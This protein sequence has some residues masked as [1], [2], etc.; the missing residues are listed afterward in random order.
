MLG[1]RE[2]KRVKE[3]W[4]VSSDVHL[5]HVAI[6]NHQP[7]AAREYCASAKVCSALN[8]ESDPNG[9]NKLSPRESLRLCP[10][11]PNS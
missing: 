9:S 2:T 1:N 8:C 3:S 10:L 4:G 7:Q 5:D 6:S 11:L